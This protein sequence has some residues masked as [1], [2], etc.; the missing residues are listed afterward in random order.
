MRNINIFVCFTHKKQNKQ[1]SHSQK[2]F[3]GVPDQVG[4]KGLKETVV[5]FFK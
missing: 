2:T 4:L 5:L 1:K 3:P